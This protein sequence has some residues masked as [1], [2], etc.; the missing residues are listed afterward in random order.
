MSIT[1]LLLV[2]LVL[3][4]ACASHNLAA[5]VEH[6]DT[7][8]ALCGQLREPFMFWM[9]R[10]L[11][12]SPDAK[13][14]AQLTN[15]EPIRFMAR[16][17]IELGGYRLPARH[18]RGY[19]LVAQ[20]NATLAD[21]LVGA[22]EPFR[23]S[24]LDVYIFDYRGYGISQGK[25]RLGAITGDYGEITSH[26]NRAGYDTRLLYGISMGGVILLN[27]VGR[28]LEY[29]RMVVDSSPAR[30][31]DLGCPRSYDPVEHLPRDA[32]RLM[33]ISGGRDTVVTPAQ[34]DELVRAAAARGAR[35]MQDPEFAHPHQDAPDTQRRREEAILAFLRPSS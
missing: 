24:G 16:D 14:L 18:A 25:S 33:I 15:V 10:R 8:E 7:E 29:D 6:A 31:S 19:L 12:G 3:A 35:V 22:L 28:A 9:W 23:D 30:I 17:G 21:Q 11:A 26:L 5:A 13:R 34:M 32:S 1:W 2:C 4:P 27:A 20:G